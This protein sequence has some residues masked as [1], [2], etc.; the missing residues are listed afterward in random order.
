[1]LFVTR[2]ADGMVLS[3]IHNMKLIGRHFQFAFI[4]ERFKHAYRGEMKEIRVAAFEKFPNI[5]T[6]RRFDW[7]LESFRKHRSS[8][9]TFAP[10]NWRII[11]PSPRRS[12]DLGYVSLGIESVFHAFRFDRWADVPNSLP[13]VQDSGTFHREW[14]IPVPDIRCDAH[15]SCVDRC[16]NHIYRIWH[17]DFG[18]LWRSVQLKVRPVWEVSDS[19]SEQSATFRDLA[20]WGSIDNCQQDIL[21]LICS[22]REFRHETCA[23]FVSILLGYDFV[24]KWKCNSD[25]NYGTLGSWIDGVD[26]L[27]CDRIDNHFLHW[28]IPLA[29]VRWSTRNRKSNGIFWCCSI[30]HTNVYSAETNDLT[31]CYHYWNARAAV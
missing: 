31:Q 7:S 15:R 25:R 17:E 8:V 29:L 27:L 19:L 21:V 14:P 28:L 26:F 23:I 4:T 18:D 5:E 16:T 6:N 12:M 1:M 11:W 2:K 20:V 9:G 3:T 13:V 10:R 24:S 22:T 30:A